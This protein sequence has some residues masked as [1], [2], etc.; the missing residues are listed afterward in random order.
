MTDL[1][2]ELKAYNDAM[3]EAMVLDDA[4]ALRRQRR[5]TAAELGLQPA[6]PL[7]ETAS[8][9]AR[10]AFLNELHAEASRAGLLAE[11]SCC[12]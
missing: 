5:T 6:D 7:D 2:A 12:F 11:D 3:T 8:I 10:I 4:S 1:H 9:P